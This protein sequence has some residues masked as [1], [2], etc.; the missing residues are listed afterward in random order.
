MHLGE[1]VKDGTSYPQA[2]RHLTPVVASQIIAGYEKRLRRDARPDAAHVIDKNPLNFRYL[3]FIAMLFPQAR[4]I[5]CTRDPL[6]TCL[7]NYFTRFPLSLDYS[8]DLRNLGH[9]YRE[10]TRLMEHWRKI[11]SLKFL[12]VSYEDLILK[13]EPAAR[14][15]LDF[16]GLPWDARCLTP[17]TNPNPVET[18]SDWQV[19]QPIYRQSLERWRHYEKQL[20]PLKEALAL[21]PA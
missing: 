4:I 1:M 12:N 14:R 3:G 6:D 17:H 18:A 7:S 8:F 19:R 2:A 15:L 10:Y 21:G 9:F 5:H 13:T 20:G 16:L 11:P